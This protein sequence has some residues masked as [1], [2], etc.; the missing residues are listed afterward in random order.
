[1]SEKNL[2]K[3]IRTISNNVYIYITRDNRI[4]SVQKEWYDEL[5]ITDRDNAIVSALLENGIQTEVRDV[6]F[7]FSY[8]PEELWN[9]IEN[10]VESLTL[11]ITQQCTL[12]CSYCIYSG[13][14]RE[15]RTH[16]EKHMSRAMLCNCID[17]YYDHSQESQCGSISFYGGESLLRFHDIQFSV[18]YAERKWKNKP[19]S[20]QI[21]T[22]GTTL[23]TEVL[24]WLE[25]H[26][27]VSIL[28]TCNGPTQDIYRLFP[29]GDGSLSVV[30]Q[31][32][33][34]IRDC[35]PNIWKRTNLLA[36]VATI[37]EFLNLRK[38]YIEQVGKAPIDITGIK[39]EYGNDVIQTMFLAKDS[40]ANR[41]HA[42]QLFCE[43]DLYVRHLA[44]ING[45]CTRKIGTESEK[46]RRPMFCRPLAHSLFISAEGK[47]RPCEEMC[48]DIDFGN[49]FRGY[50]KEKITEMLQT[51]HEVFEKRCQ[52]CWARRLCS[53]CF[54][55]IHMDNHD[56]LFLPEA[57]CK[58]QR[59]MIETELRLFCEAGERNPKLIQEI[60]NKY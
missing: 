21:S 33:N 7:N 40:E 39:R 44:N 13:N 49:I 47:F 43:N 11:E 4:V 46:E 3:A 42:T 9:A 22:N 27:N 6:D 41:E 12:R 14:Y 10:N 34:R 48:S 57:Y 25:N 50:S 23:T 5:P 1:M 54:A 19:I 24:E 60:R 59:K 16:S 58:E 29:N 15:E 55:N 28:M 45:I 35:Y 52:Y 2:I 38:F 31:A 56:K 53:T 32:I 8:T 20:F 51:I 18:E 37:E 26:S 36:N 30:M 17:Y